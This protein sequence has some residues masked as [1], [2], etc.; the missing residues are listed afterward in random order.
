M[1]NFV[2]TYTPPPVKEREALVIFYKPNLNATY[3]YSGKCTFA[4]HMEWGLNAL[5]YKVMT[6]KRALLCL[7]VDNS[8]L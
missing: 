7:V 3:I 4:E 5:R 8:L 6:Y 1:L 2:S